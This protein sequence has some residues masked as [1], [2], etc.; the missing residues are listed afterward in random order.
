MYKRTKTKYP[1][2]DYADEPV[3]IYDDYWPELGELLHM[4]N[5]YS[6]RT[7]VWGDTRYGKNIC[8]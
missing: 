6:T 4:S 1:F 3:I 7:P 8:S 5:C 2:D